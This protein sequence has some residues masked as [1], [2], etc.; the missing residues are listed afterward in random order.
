LRKLEKLKA[1]PEE[2]FFSDFRNIEATTHLLQIAIEAMTDICT[3]ILA[4]NLP[5]IFNTKTLADYPC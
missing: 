4:K 2:Q 5:S 3:H 1:I